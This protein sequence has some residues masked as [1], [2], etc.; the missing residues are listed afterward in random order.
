M[1][2]PSADFEAAVMGMVV[3]PEPFLHLGYQ[4]C[5]EAE[6]LGPNTKM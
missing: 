6:S 1:H 4:S 5:K 2:F 3:L